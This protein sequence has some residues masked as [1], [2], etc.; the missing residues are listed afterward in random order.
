MDIRLKIQTETIK[1]NII[2]QFLTLAEL[3]KIPCPECNGSG[4]TGLLNDELLA[5]NLCKA[6][7]GSG[8]ATG[9]N[10]PQELKNLISKLQSEIDRY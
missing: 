5:I 10:A 3:L 8:L 6:C 4:K 9:F 1:A 7:G 2:G